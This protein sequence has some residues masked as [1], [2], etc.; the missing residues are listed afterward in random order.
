MDYQNILNIKQIVFVMLFWVNLVKISQIGGPADYQK[1]W[2]YFYPCSTEN[3]KL[4][5]VEEQLPNQTHDCHWSNITLSEMNRNVSDVK[6][7]TGPPIS[8]PAVLRK[9]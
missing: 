9:S 8:T 7:S 2:S 5:F 4:M 3:F 1:F 6:I